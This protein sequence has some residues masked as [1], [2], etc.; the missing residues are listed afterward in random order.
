MK[1][2]I[3]VVS[4]ILLSACATSKFKEKWLKEQSPNTFKARFETTQGNFDIVARRLWSPNGVDRLY[5][6]IQ[7]KYYTDVAIFRVVPKFVA[8]FGIHNDSLI[9]HSWEKGIAD[10]PVLA[11]N[12]SMTISF[13]RGGV[14]SRSNQIFINLKDNKRLDTLAYSG[15]TGFPVVAKVIA[16]QE[17]VLKFYNGYGDKLGFKQ[18]SITKFGNKFLREKFPKVDYIIKAY[19]IK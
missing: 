1:K 6:M 8:Q 15:V 14:N 11:K 18:D 19:I 5:Q 7:H 13:A 17:N 10:E 2:I 3:L 12:D 4:V 9:N 16:G